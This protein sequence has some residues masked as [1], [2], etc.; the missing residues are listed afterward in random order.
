MTLMCFT[1]KLKIEKKKKK[2]ASNCV[3]FSYGGAKAF[4]L[5]F[6]FV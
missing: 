4:L 2:K 5:L 3:S 1:K 6:I